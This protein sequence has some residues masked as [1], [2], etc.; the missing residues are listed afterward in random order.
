MII[1]MFINNLWSLNLFK[2][3]NI[4]LKLQRD[5]DFH[6]TIIRI[7]GITKIESGSNNKI[8]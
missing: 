2:I 3:Y 5:V 6:N 4:Q 8:I 7:Y 1:T